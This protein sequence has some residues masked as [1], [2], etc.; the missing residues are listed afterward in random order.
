MK[1][2]V[3]FLSNTVTNPIHRFLLQYECISFEINTI[4]QTL[5]RS[6][7]VDYL[8][9]LLD[10]N[11]FASDGFIDDN[12]F[13][14]LSDLSSLLKVFR[15]NNDAKLIVSNV[16]GDYLDINS[17]LNIELHE[18]IMT[19][20]FEI[21]K[22]SIIEDL[23]IL[24]LYQIIN[25]Y[26]FKNFYNIKNSFLFQAPWTK[27]ALTIIA[28]NIS[29]RIN[30]FTNLR[31]KII[32]L[33]ADNTLWGGIVGE[34]G[35]DNIN[36]DE[37]YPGIAYRFFQKQIKYL[38]DSG[39]LLAIASKNNLS[40]IEEVFSKKNMPLNLDD[41]V[42]KKVNWRPKSQNIT[43]I[44]NE[45]N[46]GLESAIFI[47]DSDFELSEV[48]DS[49]GI[50]VIKTSIEN[51]IDNLSIFSNLLSIKTLIITK[52]DKNK[53]LQYL[54]ETSR[55]INNNKFKNIDDYLSD[56]NMEI[57]MSINNLSQIKRITQLINKTNQFNS[58]AKR[59]NETEVL[60]K[61]KD[62]SIFSFGLLDKFGDLGLISVVIINNNNIDLFLMSCRAIG[63][64]IEQKILYLISSHLNNELTAS[65]IKNNKNKPVESF[66][67]SLSL[68][69]HI[70]DS[71]LKTYF[72][73]KKIN[74]V[75]FIRNIK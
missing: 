60:K 40:D 7:D 13:T 46:I 64:K 72:F 52:E 23:A 3:A 11:Y 50:E 43:E 54:Q 24:N 36:I 1:K 74:D 30:L 61:M 31:K 62:S 29:E 49:L 37:N 48:K 22:L 28:E 9:L 44:L 19:L 67:D 68:K 12:S 10:I 27:T 41:F 45:L 21:D 39:I 69:D 16:A 59:Y 32:I 73:P 35:V 58:T 38:K 26:G 63:R 18:Q 15:K 65:Y 8:V 75:K 70:D 51:P 34:D 47:D 14:K 53:T 5:N 6:M 66:F 2:K 25:Y 55:K 57:S 71:G 33:D 20:N 17:S 42:I 4:V 56:I